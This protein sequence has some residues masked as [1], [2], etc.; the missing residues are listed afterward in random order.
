MVSRLEQIAGRVARAVGSEQN[1]DEILESASL[2]AELAREFEASQN[3]LASGP[4]EGTRTVLLAESDPSERLQIRG[5][6]DRLD[7]AVL[8]V[9]T[10]A[11]ALAI[12]GADP[13][14]IDLMVTSASLP[15][16]SGFELAERAR[17]VRPAMAVV[18]VTGEGRD[19][20]A[21]QLA[22][23]LEVEYAG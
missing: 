5:L 11:E 23:A 14:P 7:C 6:L 20:L 3:Q 21:R 8:E 1:P 2:V 4:E 18:S 9:R 13:G 15:D 12:C 10:G 17:S 19:D 22:E 16:M